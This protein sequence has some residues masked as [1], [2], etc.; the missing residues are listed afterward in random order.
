MLDNF[1]GFG[2]TYSR[3]L[4]GRAEFSSVALEGLRQGEALGLRWQ[5]VDLRSGTLAVRNSLQRINGVFRLVE[6]KTRRSRRTV[7]LP[8]VVVAQLR[9]HRAR[10]LEERLRA[11][12]LWEDHGLVFATELGRP[13]HAS[14]VTIR[15]Q[16]VLERAGLRRQRFHDLRHACAS[17]LLAQGVSPRVVMEVL[18]HSQVTLTLNT[19][20]HV[21]PSLGREAGDRMEDLLRLGPE[22]GESPA[23]HRQESDQPPPVAL[24]VALLTE[25]V[26]PFGDTIGP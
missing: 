20:S 1:F 17:L 11:A 8:A 12:Q 23:R 24:R 16:R 18:G 19:Y 7:H 2:N 6:P 3:W 22:R 25:N 4:T 21:I 9:A 10:Q 13:L 5:D 14:S 26:P 15:F